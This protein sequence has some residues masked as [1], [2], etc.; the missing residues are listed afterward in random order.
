MF[1]GGSG[2]AGKITLA[3]EILKNFSYRKS[4]KGLYL[5]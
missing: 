4:K 1:L 3:K 5:N 2:Q